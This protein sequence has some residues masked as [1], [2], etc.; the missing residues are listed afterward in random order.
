M[1]K[2]LLAGL[3]LTAAVARAQTPP[4]ITMADMPAAGD[5]LRLSRAAAVLPASAP[6]LTLN[7]AN[8]TWN[9]AGLVATS[10]RV[11]RY[12]T[13]ASAATGLQ[14]LTFGLPFGANRANL[15]SP[16]DLGVAGGVLPVSDPAEFFLSSSADF[17]S[18]GF[19]VTVNGLALPITYLSQ[20]RQDVVYHLPQAYGNAADGSN[21]FFEVAVPGTGALSR[22]RQRTNLPDAWGTLTTPFGTFQTLRVVTTIIDR[23]SVVFGALSLPATTLPTQREYKWLAKGVHVPILTITTTEVAGAQQVTAVE[24]RD[25]FRRFVVPLAGRDAATEAVLSAAPNPSAVGTDLRLTVPAGSGPLTV[26]ATDVVGRQVF[27]RRFSSG[28]GA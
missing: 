12:G 5:S 22:R 14:L 8:K 18:V 10:Q 19:G 15:A 20:A 23:D 16:R 1:R 28:T 24:Y 13:V 4:S 2:L 26:A 25:S 17:R 3:T 27:S 21:S 11:E 9:Y 7:G 6:A